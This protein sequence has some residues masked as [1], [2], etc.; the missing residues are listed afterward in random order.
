M[1]AVLRVEGLG[2]RYGALVALDGV[3]WEVAAGEVL[4][5]IG[6]NG[7]GKSSCYDAATHMTRRTGR[8]W[9]DGREVTAVPP[10]GL[11]TLGLKRAFQQNAFFAQLSVLENMVAVLQ[12][13]GGAGLAASLALPWREARLRRALRAEAAALLEEFGVPR[14]MHELRPGHIPYGSQRMLSIVLAWGRGARVLMLDEPAAGLGGPDMAR[15]R[16]LLQRLRGRGTALV[17]IEHHMDLIM[18]VADRILVLEQGRPLA[19]G[20]PR[21]IQQDARVLEAYLGRAA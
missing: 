16:D 4:G 6:P 15:L 3:S 21:E 1:T 9:L 10:H 19:S 20:T 5:I 11:A 17:V 12:R 7:A 8:V 13:E 2:V 18:S 14:E